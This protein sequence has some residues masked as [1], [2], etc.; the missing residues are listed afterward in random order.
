MLLL[1]FTS[2][3]RDE[4][5]FPD[6]DRFDVGRD[7]RTAHVAFSRGIHTCIGMMLSRK[8]LVVA[9]R[10]SLERLD[11]IRLDPAHPRPRY[12]PSPLFR[13]VHELHITFRGRRSA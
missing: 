8:E 4:R 11:D 10:R 9:F 6:P 2:A 5:Y 3:N 13:G 1:M 12:I 7:F